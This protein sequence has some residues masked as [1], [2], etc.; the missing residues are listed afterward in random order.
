M[1]QINNKIH[2]ISEDA[3]SKLCALTW[4][5][6]SA[7]SSAEPLLGVGMTF[8]SVAFTGSGSCRHQK[9]TGD[10]FTH[11]SH[12]YFWHSRV[13]HEFC[14]SKIKH[15]LMYSKHA[16]QAE[17]ENALVHYILWA[18]SLYCIKKVKRRQESTVSSL[19][20]DLTC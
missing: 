11:N 8:A 6:C 7:T 13:P 20:A 3:R 14:S 9:K 10:K 16:F 12:T 19:R 5:L 4:S 17:C 15:S 18:F 2:I 1:L